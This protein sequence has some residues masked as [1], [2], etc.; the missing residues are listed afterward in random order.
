MEENWFEEFHL[1]VE[2]NKKRKKKRKLTS[3]V[4]L[5]FYILSMPV[6]FVG[7]LNYN[8]F[9]ALLG[10]SFIPL[11]ILFLIYSLIAGRVKQSIFPEDKIIYDL[12][13]L[14]HLIENYQKTKVESAKK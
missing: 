2:G 11:A 1:I 9:I 3:I 7:A 14:T 12:K 8:V 6:M 5:I 10:I 4:G 13:S